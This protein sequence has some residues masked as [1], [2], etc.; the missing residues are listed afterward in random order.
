VQN[1]DVKEIGAKAAVEVLR[2][3]GISAYTGSRLD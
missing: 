2:K 1:I 3:Y